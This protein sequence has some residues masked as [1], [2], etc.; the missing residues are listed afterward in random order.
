MSNLKIINSA[1]V[2][3]TTEEISPFVR[4]KCDTSGEMTFKVKADGHF[5]RKLTLSVRGSDSGCSYTIKV[6]GGTVNGSTE[7]HKN[8]PVK[9]I[10]H[11]TS[12]GDL[13]FQDEITDIE[14]EFTNEATITLKQELPTVVFNHERGETWSGVPLDCIDCSGP[15]HIGETIYANSWMDFLGKHFQINAYACPDF[16]GV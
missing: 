1:G 11:E 2:G 13:A 16:S 10:L 12:R 8:Y 9:P 6:Q 14:L 4:T 7:F 15:G 3:Y 5:K